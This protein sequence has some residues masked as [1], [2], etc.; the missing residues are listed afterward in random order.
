[1]SDKDQNRT[2][3]DYYFQKPHSA[4]DT[5]TEKQAISIVILVKVTPVAHSYVRKV[6]TNSN[7]A[8]MG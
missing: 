2:Q 1:M 6:R 3:N 5:R 7:Q 8:I 4:L